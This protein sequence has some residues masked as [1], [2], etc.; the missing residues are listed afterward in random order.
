MYYI[1]IYIHILSAIFWIGGMMFTMAVL[2]P[3][4]RNKLLVQKRGAFFKLVGEKFSKISW[5]LFLVLI[6]TGITNLTGRGIPLESLLNTSFWQSEFGSRLFMKLHLFAGVLI[7]SGIHDFYA[8]PKAAE[9][10]DKNPESSKTQTF[11]K[12]SSWIGR[13]NFL[14]GLA[15][16]YYAI[17]LARG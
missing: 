14:L 13:I 15:I 5:I 16:L 7:L 10:I 3:A 6:I 17:R 11:R 12:V 9:L 8:G 1:S 4:S 2:V